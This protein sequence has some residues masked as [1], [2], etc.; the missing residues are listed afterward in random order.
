MNSPRTVGTPARSSRA[1][2]A[3]PAASGPVGAEHRAAA[4][5]LPRHERAAVVDVN[6]LRPAARRS[7]LGAARLPAAARLRPCPTGSPRQA[8]VIVDEAEQDRL[9]RAT[10]GPCNASPIHSSFGARASNR[11]N[12][13]DDQDGRPF[14]PTLTKWRWIVRSAGPDPSRS[15]MIRTICAAVRS[16]ASRLS[17]TASSSNPDRRARHPLAR[18]RNERLKPALTPRPHPPIQRHPRDRD[19]LAP[20]RQML[21]RGQLTHRPPSRPWRHRRQVANQ[22]ITEKSDIPAT[23]GVHQ[24]SIS[25]SSQRR[26]GSPL[27]AARSRARSCTTIRRPTVNSPAATATASP[28]SPPPPECTARPPQPPPQAHRHH[29]PHRRRPVPDRARTPSR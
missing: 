2:A 10:T 22:R 9:P 25:T 24:R 23:I 27:T 26:A 4:Q 20:R 16:G 14:R 18:C 1:P 3:V 21:A 28:T 19:P 6:P 13:S 12:A 15:R 11:P 29:Q 7:G 17:A 8:A 5:Q